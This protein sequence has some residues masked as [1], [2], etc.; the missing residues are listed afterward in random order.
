MTFTTHKLI[1]RHVVFT[2]TSSSL[3]FMDQYSLLRTIINYHVNLAD[4]FPISFIFTKFFR[5]YAM[6][7]VTEMCSIFLVAVKERKTSCELRD[8]ITL[9]L[10]Y[11]I[12]GRF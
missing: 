1:H 10:L 12:T 11:I 9:C 7:F 3:Y 8:N 6:R 5:F 2:P 4:L